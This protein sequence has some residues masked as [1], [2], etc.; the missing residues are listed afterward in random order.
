MKR[1]L[2]LKATQLYVEDVGVIPRIRRQAP[3][4]RTPMKDHHKLDNLLGKRVKHQ[5]EPMQQPLLKWRTKKFGMMP[6]T[7]AKLYLL[8]MGQGCWTYL[9]FP[10]ILEK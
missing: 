5:P 6:Q 10:K 1:R 9:G 8:R 4:N 3:Q 2:I 7:K